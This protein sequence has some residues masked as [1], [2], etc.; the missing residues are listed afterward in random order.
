M[1]RPAQNYQFSLLHMDHVELGRRWNYRQVI[2]PYYR[3]YYIDA[4]SGSITDVSGV[5]TLE[6]GYLYLIPSFTL[7]DL[8][9]PEYLSQYFVQFF[10]ETAN[11]LSLFADNRHVMKVDAS[12]EDAANF[13]RLLMI[14]PGRGINRSDNPKVYERATYYKEY[15]ELNNLQSMAASLETHGIIQQLLA[16]FVNSPGF[17]QKETRHIPGRIMEAISYI[18]L[19]VHQKISVKELAARAN[20][21]SEHFSRMFQRHTGERPVRYIHEKR[22][23]RA[24][25]LMVSTRMTFEEIAAQTGFDSVSH[26]SRIFKQVTGRTPGRYRLQLRS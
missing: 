7:C 3:I 15:Q 5:H 12:P 10:E 19:H 23:E 20:Q 26:F 17:N 2:S 8:A 21:N 24:Q 18:A 22:I 1:Q 4:G 25:Y 6:P 11:G 13:R 9:C 16:R 14:N